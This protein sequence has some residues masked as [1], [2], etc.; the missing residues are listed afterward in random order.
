[1]LLFVIEIIR[2]AFP[3][4]SPRVEGAWT[5]DQIMAVLQEMEYDPGRQIVNLIEALLQEIALDRNTLNGIVVRAGGGGDA[6]SISI[7]R[8]RQVMPALRSASVLVLDGTGSP[9]LNAQLFPG[10]EHVHIRIE[11]SACVTGTIGKNYSRQSLT[12]SDRSGHP[13]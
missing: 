3:N 7:H 6:A 1:N 13:L 4:R 2:A 8:L 10:I 11:R 9:V 12:G 5:D